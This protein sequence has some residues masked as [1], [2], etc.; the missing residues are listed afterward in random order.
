MPILN[1]NYQTF[2]RY[3][4]YLTSRARGHIVNYGLGDWYDLGPK[5]PGFAQLTPVA[6]TSTA[7]YYRDLVTL[8]RISTVLGETPKAEEYAALANRVKEAFNQKFFHTATD[9]YA[10]GSQTSNA[11]PLALGMAP[12][13]A[14]AGLLKNIIQDIRSHGNE[15]TTGEVGF[16]SL[17]GVLREA[18]RSGVI[19][20]MNSRTTP[21]GYGYI[22]KQ[23][24]TTLT[25]SWTAS[26]RASQNHFMLGQ[27]E[28]WFYKGLAGIS[29]APDSIGYQ[30]IVIKP[31]PVG[32]ITWCKGSY[33]SVRGEIRSYLSIKNGEFN[34]DV[35]LPPDTSD[36]L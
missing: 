10:T 28:A 23:G 31:Q 5:P 19:F 27:I 11:L 33:R 14:R 24:A 36:Q 25:E 1:D 30:K 13:S 34:L 9:S 8:A 3:A 35:T 26:R 6:L 20:D 17:L 16:P 29:Q 7:T 21:P 12:A 22:L 4:A 15:M 32:N 2:E 18:D